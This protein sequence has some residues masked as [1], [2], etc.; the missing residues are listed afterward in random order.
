MT[1][2][3]LILM[4]NMFGVNVVK[5]GNV[6]IQQFNCSKS[7]IETLEKGVKCLQS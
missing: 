6:L 3:Y 4:L 5:A 7:T 1:Q 2:V